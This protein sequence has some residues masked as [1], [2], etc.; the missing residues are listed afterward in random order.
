MAGPPGSANIILLPP[1]LFTAILQALESRQTITIIR[2]SDIQTEPLAG[3]ATTKKA[4]C[5]IAKTHSLV[6]LII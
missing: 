3:D 4:L 6:P 1:G 5:M 2:Q